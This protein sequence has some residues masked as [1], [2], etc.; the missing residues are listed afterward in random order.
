MRGIQE[1]K[2]H[3][4]QSLAGTC[5]LVVE[6]EVII[7]MM[8]S[9]EIAHAGGIPVGPVTS[10]AA[11]LEEIDSQVIDAVILDAKLID[12]SAEELAASL[13]EHCIP[14][15]VTSG[16]EKDNLPRGLRGAPF[17]AKPIS[18]PLLVETLVTAFER[19]PRPL[20]STGARKIEPVEGMQG[21]ALPDAIDRASPLLVVPARHD[22]TDRQ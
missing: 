3:M 12:G 18:A 17:V 14:Y 9:S 11:A 8:I 7:G 21:A 1:G 20:A 19:S 6:D 15:V 16:Y 10:V 5:V 4:R 13:K 22:E 2:A